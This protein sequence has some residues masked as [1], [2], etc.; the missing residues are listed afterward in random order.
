MTMNVAI[1]QARLDSQRFPGKVLAEICGKPMLLHVI[2]R[3]RKAQ[4]VERVIVAAP[5]SGGGATIK[6][7]CEEWEAECM[8]TPHPQSDVLA[9]FLRVASRAKAERIVRV[10][11]DNPMINPAGIDELLEAAAEHGADY[12]GYRAVDGTPMILRPS[13]WFAEVVSFGALRRANREVYGPSRAR[14]HV[15]WWMY[16]MPRQYSCHWLDLPAWYVDNDLPNT[17]IDFP[18]DIEKLESWLAEFD[19]KE[20][21]PWK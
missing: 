12:T 20:N 4:H 8:V 11:A 18:E 5:A 3:V 17:A 2:E 15:T 19:N 13:G 1:I 6:G 7:H 9:R 10:C 14:E 16:Q 21:W